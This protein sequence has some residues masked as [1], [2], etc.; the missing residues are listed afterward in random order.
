M[1]GGF[2][3]PKNRKFLTAIII[4]ILVIVMIVPMIL[5]YIL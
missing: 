5:G 4:I 2:Y 3:D 1:A